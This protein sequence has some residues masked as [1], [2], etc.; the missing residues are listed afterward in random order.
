[1]IVAKS[2]PSND[3]FPGPPGNNVSPVNSRGASTT[4][5]DT[6]PGVCP[7]L[8]IASRRSLPTSMTSA[9]SMNTS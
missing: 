1:M 7:G 5:N 9:S 3:V 6:E 8:W 2:D 4:L